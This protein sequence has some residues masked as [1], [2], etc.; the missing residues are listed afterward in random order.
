[1]RIGFGATLVAVL[2]IGAAA[3]SGDWLRQSQSGLEQLMSGTLAPRHD[4]TVETD[5]GI[6]AGWRDPQ[7]KSA[8]PSIA[9]SESDWLKLADDLAPVSYLA[10][11]GP[12]PKPTAP[13]EQ[14]PL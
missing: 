7:G 8:E 1:M 11:P 9:M 5:M 6:L 12:A 13:V 3:I 10:E 14:Q 2:L 4:L